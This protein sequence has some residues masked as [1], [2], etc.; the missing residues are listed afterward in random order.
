MQISLGCLFTQ[1]L[2]RVQATKTPHPVPYLQSRSVLRNLSHGCRPPILLELQKPASQSICEPLTSSSHI[3]IVRS[4]TKLF[5]E[6]FPEK[7]RH[8]T[9]QLSPPLSFPHGSISIIQSRYIHMADVLLSRLL[10]PNTGEEPD[11]LIAVEYCP[12]NFWSK[13]R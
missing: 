13:R 9:S 10:A 12:L 7:P 11:H 3:A 8:L 6:Y 2:Q 4:R 1:L 5:D